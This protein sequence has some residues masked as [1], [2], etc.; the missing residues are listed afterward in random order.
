MSAAIGIG[1]TLGVIGGYVYLNWFVGSRI[2]GLI[3]GFFARDNDD[4]IIAV[5]E[6]RGYGH[7]VWT[8]ISRADQRFKYWFF[9]V[10]LPI[11]LFLNYTYWDVIWATMES[12]ANTLMRFF[13]SLLL[14]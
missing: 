13:A 10:I 7:S 11:L 5:H 12:V 9:L 6:D 2:A 8:P 14:H 4:E 3:A 1:V